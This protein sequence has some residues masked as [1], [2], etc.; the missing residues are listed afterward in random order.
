MNTRV[1]GG[2]VTERRPAPEEAVTRPPAPGLPALL[3]I[4]ICA[5]AVAALGEFGILGFE[6]ARGR[7]IGFGIPAL[8]MKPLAEMLLFAG[9]TLA[10]W[11]VGR[12]ARRVSFRAY[13]V[14]WGALGAYS[15]QL[16]YHL[17]L[18]PAAALLIAVA[19]GVQLA[20]LTAARVDR[21]AAIARV[22]APLA[23]L[24]VAL[25]AGITIWQPWLPAKARGV[26]PPRAPNVL[27]I[28]L[29]AVRAQSLGLYGY[30]RPTTPFL[31]RFAREGVRV[32]LA[33]APAPWTAPSHASFFTGE[34]ANKA[35]P[36]RRR[37]C[38]PGLPTIAGFLAANGY[39][40]GAFVGNWEVASAER[41]FGRGFEV[42]QDQPVSVSAL[43]RHSAI[44]ATVAWQP[45]LRSVLGA[46]Q[47]LGR[48]VGSDVVE[49]CV[50]WVAGHRAEPYFAFVNLY[51]AHDPYLPGEPFA[52]RFERGR[53][54]DP[55]M[56][57]RVVAGR[58]GTGN[59]RA[60][61]G[62]RDAYDGTIAEVDSFV[63]RLIGELRDR[64]ALDNTLVIVTSDH[65][66][67]FDEQGRI[68]H[69]WSL[70]PAL[71][72]VP[73][74]VVWPGHVP[75]GVVAPG[76]VSLSDLPT[77]I[78]D[79]VGLGARAPFPGRS[80]ASAWNPG[81][82]PGRDRPVVAE[83]ERQQAVAIGTR[84]FVRHRG[85]QEQLFDLVADPLGLRDLA[86]RYG[87]ERSAYRE[88]LDRFL[89]PVEPPAAEQEPPGAGPDSDR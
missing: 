57:R 88:A 19:V 10:L 35:C 49:E 23:A 52:A 34:V 85:G 68:G 45:G 22:G 84:L 20:R 29:D 47:T 16:A 66:E 8:W 24:V 14:L 9:L 15:V 17:R 80:F 2:P 37:P 6:R 38:T 55:W 33:I 82:G 77:T 3:Q 89:G 83:V 78:S 1:V 12:F 18:H 25:T 87:P 44:V 74:V 71:L 62:E 64:G 27:F 79:L 81:V 46:W 43:A 72:R 13:V 67:E 51:D 21:W 58:H 86:E 61:E 69:G 76:P 73:L 65:G 31:D 36:G 63:E 41:G 40:T 50:R 28:V 48:H 54:R 32:D 7:L 5:G 30:D 42:Y 53:A 39:R 26:P 59:R 56:V 70:A 75:R 11:A 60:V 4:A